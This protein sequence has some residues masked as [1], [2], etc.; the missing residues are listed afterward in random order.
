MQEVEVNYE[1]EQSLARVEVETG[2]SPAQQLEV[3]NKTLTY[4]HDMGVKAGDVVL[5]REKTKQHLVS[6]TLADR[7]AQ[8]DYKLASRQLDILEEV[9]TAHFAERKDIIKSGFRTIDKALEEGNWDAVAKVY[10]DMSAMV[11]KS[12]LAAAIELGNKMKS[13]KAITLDDF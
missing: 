7:N 5:E 12:P 2:I 13:G 8:R 3:V 11:A 4:L 6:A 1:G 10:G 9:L